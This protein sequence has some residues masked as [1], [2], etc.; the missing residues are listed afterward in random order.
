MVSICFRTPSQVKQ[1]VD[2]GILEYE[3][4]HGDEANAFCCQDA[5]RVPFFGDSNL[6]RRVVC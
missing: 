2:P 5:A 4:N 6:K 1:A 3:Y